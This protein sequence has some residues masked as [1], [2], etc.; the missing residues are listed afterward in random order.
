MLRLECGLPN[1]STFCS[2]CLML[3][4]RIRSTVP[5]RIINLVTQDQGTCSGEQAAER[6]TD[7]RER[8][9]KGR[10]SRFGERVARVIPQPPKK[11]RGCWVGPKFLGKVLRTLREE[12]THIRSW[13]S[14]CLMMVSPNAKCS[15]RNIFARAGGGRWKRR[16]WDERCVEVRSGP[17]EGPRVRPHISQQTTW[18]SPSLCVCVGVCTHGGSLLL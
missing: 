18:I 12:E 3:G 10:P 16:G 5:C 14:P 2:G 4:P 7:T 6:G 13:F 15:S 1:C 17:L 8:L 9:R 11:M